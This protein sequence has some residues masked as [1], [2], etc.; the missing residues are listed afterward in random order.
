MEIYSLIQEGKHDEAAKIVAEH[1]T[2][3]L[4][5]AKEFGW[6]ASLKAGLYEMGIMALTERPP[7]QPIPDEQRAEL[8]AIMKEV[9]WI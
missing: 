1:E 2:K 7:M 3:F 4:D 6:H 9:G 8:R 5:K